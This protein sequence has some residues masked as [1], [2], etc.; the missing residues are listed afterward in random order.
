[1]HPDLPVTMHQ[2]FRT[3]IDEA[4]VADPSVS[5]PPALRQHLQSCERC[6]QYLDTSARVIGTLGSYSFAIEPSLNA[7]VLQALRLRAAQLATHPHPFSR[8]QFARACVAAV[9]FTASGSLID[10]EFGSLLASLF[11]LHLHALPGSEG[12]RALWLLTTLG[13]LLLFPLLPFLSRPLPSRSPF[14]PP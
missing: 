14:S 5:Q 8:S 12:L 13:A 10:L 6:R 1:M 4:M 7:N 3:M 9:I 11:H 2:S